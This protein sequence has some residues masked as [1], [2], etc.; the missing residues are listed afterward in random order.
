MIDSLE[1]WAEDYKLLELRPLASPTEV[2]AAYLQML[3]VWHPDRFPGDPAL[4]HR[5][6]EK[7]KQITAAYGRIRQAPL[8]HVGVKDAQA[9]RPAQ[10]QQQ[11]ASPPPNRPTPPPPMTTSGPGRGKPW[12]FRV[13]NA[14]DIR[15]HRENLADALRHNPLTAPAVWIIDIF[16]RRR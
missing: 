16:R 5:A 11:H 1:Q 8:L 2:R 13:D 15:R 9:A 12:E 4:R 6:E 14:D 3:K 10:R 7:S